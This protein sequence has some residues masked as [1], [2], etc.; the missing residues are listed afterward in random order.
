[1]FIQA[2]LSKGRKYIAGTWNKTKYGKCGKL[3]CQQ[4]LARSLRSIIKAH[5]VVI[6]IFFLVML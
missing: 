3:N 1:M 5:F 2:Q 6:Y 4:A